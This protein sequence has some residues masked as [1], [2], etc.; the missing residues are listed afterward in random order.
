MY[1][2][3]RKAID[4]SLDSLL[5]ADVYRSATTVKPEYLGA[6]PADVER[7]LTNTRK[8][9]AS[10]D[11]S[12]A[13]ALVR[14]ALDATRKDQEANLERLRKL[15]K[16]GRT[17]ELDSGIAEAKDELAALGRVIERLND[18]TSRIAELKAKGYAPLM[19]FG[20]YTVDVLN[21]QGERVWFGMYEN[22]YEANRA[23]RS[24]REKGLKVS[25]GVQSQREFELLKGVSPET[26]ML[27]AEMLG[28]EGDTAMQEWLQK[29]TAQHSALRRLIHRKGV[30][31]FDNDG[32]RVV[33]A[34]ITS[35][36][37][38]AARA[39]HG[40]RISEAVDNVKQGDVKDEAVALA[41]Y[42]QNPK[43]EA[44]AIRSLLFLNYIG[45]SVASALVNLT[46][47]LVQ[48]LPYLSQF[49]GPAKAVKQVGDAMRQAVGKV[50][51]GVVRAAGGMGELRGGEVGHGSSQ[52][53]Q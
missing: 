5:A 52:S 10:E 48:T 28:I 9:A 30:E 40:L 13:V 23:A 43:E 45:G 33:A 27:F 2:Q 8:A 39:L 47:T 31:G 7:L 36:S 11:P 50:Q 46:Q 34:F 38:A 53:W 25:Q 22:Q 51:E 6:S 20:P 21:D 32:S 41:N 49:G 42:V 35:N 19:R 12:E 4:Q 14:N 3:A 44:Q 24:F 29:A 17:P 37:R 16:E 26:A 1:Q 18:K 15:A